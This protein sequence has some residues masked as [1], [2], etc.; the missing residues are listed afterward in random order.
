MVFSLF[1]P[2]ATGG[3]WKWKG[4]AKVIQYDRY[5]GEQKCAWCGNWFRPNGNEIYCSY[6]EVEIELGIDKALD[7]K[8]EKAENK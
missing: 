7:E 4:G 6:C 8:A 3:D 1:L 5:T 2:G